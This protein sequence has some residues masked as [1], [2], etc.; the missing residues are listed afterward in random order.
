MKPTRI[1]RACAIVALSTCFASCCKSTDELTE[2]TEKKTVEVVTRSTTDIDYPLALHAFYAESGRLAKSVIAYDTDDILELPLPLGSYHLIALA[3]TDGL[4]ATTPTSLDGSIGIPESGLIGSALQMGRANIEVASSDVEVNL[5]MAYQVAQIDVELQDIPTDVTGV[6]VTLA[7]LYGD[8]TFRGTLNEPKAVS[9]PLSKQADGTTWQSNTVYTLPGSSTQLTLSIHMTSDGTSKTY[10]YTHVTN[11][12][13]GTPY[14]LVGSFKDGFNLTG[15]VTPAGW[16]AAENIA[17]TFGIEAG[18][19]TSN[20][21]Y[22]VSAIPSARTIWDGHFVACVKSTSETS[23]EVLLISLDEW[24]ATGAEAST[25]A[26]SAASDYTESSMGHW[27]IPTSEEMLKDI[28]PTLSMS[29]NIDSTNSLLVQAGGTK[30]TNGTGYLCDD[31]TKSVK[32]G[33][34]D[35]ASTVSDATTYRL[36]LVKSITVKTQE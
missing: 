30:L 27:R 7:S 32:M 28:I 11:L 23:A 6:S 29:G 12:K 24:N 16:N 31:T 26:T 25:V 9:I 10:G 3:G 17:F 36:R 18:E 20:D 4:I 34:K 5:T 1:L 2:Q 13:A 33:S 15:T 14:T 8:E 22:T 21:L 35:A 19:N